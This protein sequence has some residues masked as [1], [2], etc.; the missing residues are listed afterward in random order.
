MLFGQFV[1]YWEIAE[2]RYTRTYRTMIKL[3][4]EAHFGWILNGT[5][6]ARVL[7]NR[8]EL[9]VPVSVLSEFERHA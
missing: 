9:N 7:E 4:G 1:G 6:I 8:E 3:K 2:A 5:A